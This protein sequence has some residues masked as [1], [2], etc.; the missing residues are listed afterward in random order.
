MR[1][2]RGKRDGVPVDSYQESEMYSS[3]CQS[4]SLS[5]FV[6]VVFYSSCM[7]TWCDR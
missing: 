2:F 3:K 7:K 4:H 6:P 1:N 5:T